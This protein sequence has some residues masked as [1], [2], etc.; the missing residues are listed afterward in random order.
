MRLKVRHNGSDCFGIGRSHALRLNALQDVREQTQD[1]RVGKLRG[2]DRA[3]DISGFL[4]VDGLGLRDNAS[5]SKGLS[6]RTGRGYK[7]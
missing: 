5:R 7:S 2:L 4:H 1:F 3:D 6:N